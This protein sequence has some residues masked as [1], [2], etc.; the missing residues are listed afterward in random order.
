[1]PCATHA[2][3][4][5]FKYRSR[6]SMEFHRKPQDKSPPKAEH[7]G[8]VVPVW[9]GADYHRCPP[10]ICD[11]RCIHIQGPEWLRS[12][13]R[14]SIR[15]ECMFLDDPDGRVSGFIS[16]RSNPNHP[17]VGRGLTFHDA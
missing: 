11:V 8:R 1:M 5:G 6:H 7:E 2:D 15:V 14:W 12:H 4:M 10:S 13:K 17:R 16:L 3:K 9:V